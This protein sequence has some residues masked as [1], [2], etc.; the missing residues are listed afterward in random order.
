MPALDD[1]V[2]L[3]VRPVDGACWSAEQRGGPMP[4]TRELLLV[5]GEGDEVSDTALS[6]E[7]RSVPSF[8]WLTDEKRSPR[9][10]NMTSPPDF[11][12]SG[13]VCSM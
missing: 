11:R 13:S 12:R 6:H 9:P 7:E 3:V 8:I 4:H 1:L 2:D 10:R 5:G